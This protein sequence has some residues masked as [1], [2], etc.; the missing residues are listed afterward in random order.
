MFH[1]SYLEMDRDGD[2]EELDGLKIGADGGG[3]VVAGVVSRRWVVLIV[4]TEVV[5]PHSSGAR[6]CGAR[7]AESA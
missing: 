2:N 7:D 6:G 4:D 1:C 5:R 3:R